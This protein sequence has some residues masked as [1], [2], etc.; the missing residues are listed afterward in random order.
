MQVAD[1]LKPL[2][3]FVAAFVTLSFTDCRCLS[4]AYHRFGVA[5]VPTDF[6]K[7][8]NYA[9]CADLRLMQLICLAS[10][11]LSSYFVFH[12]CDS[13]TGRISSAVALMRTN[14]VRMQ[15]LS[16]EF[17]AL[18]IFG[19]ANF[20]LTSWLRSI[21]LQCIS[22]VCLCFCL[23][24]L[25][26]RLRSISIA[27]GM[28]ADFVIASVIHGSIEEDVREWKC[29]SNA[30]I[31]RP[32]QLTPHTFGDFHYP[33]CST[34][35]R[36]QAQIT[37]AIRNNS[38]LGMNKLPI[39]ALT[40][41]SLCTTFRWVRLTRRAVVAFMVSQITITKSWSWLW[42]SVGWTALPTASLNSLNYKCAMHKSVD[43]V[44]FVQIT[45]Q[46]Y[47]LTAFDR[48]RPC[49]DKQ[50]AAL[51]PQRGHS[52]MVW[53]SNIVKTS[54]RQWANRSIFGCPVLHCHVQP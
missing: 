38:W 47:P 11:V 32:L 23:R 18:N 31:H 1:R 25:N 19:R 51:I 46:I 3:A 34:S 12:V 48:C 17:A 44:D 41:D 20:L 2:Q 6:G 13:H 10:R 22:F 27:A 28:H 53:R 54:R 29:F 15:N 8:T 35:D 33:Q 52:T 7:L 50:W 9:N 36:N 40:Y 4:R 5:K 14:C 26:A 43:W 21:A 39:D 49:Y 37:T 42:Y 45:L 30:E 16:G 24:V